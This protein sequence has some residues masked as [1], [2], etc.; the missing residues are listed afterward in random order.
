MQKPYDDYDKIRERTL[1]VAHPM[2]LDDSLHM[3][4]ISIVKYVQT[5]LGACPE[6]EDAYWYKCNWLP[7]IEQADFTRNDLKKSLEAQFVLVDCV[8]DA[9]AYVDDDYRGKDIMLDILYERLM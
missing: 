5:L 2:V 1:Q 9:R 3:L 4:P 6:S 8:C 7:L